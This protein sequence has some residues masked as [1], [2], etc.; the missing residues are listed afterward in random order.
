MKFRRR[1]RRASASKRSDGS[2]SRRHSNNRAKSW[3]DATTPPANRGFS[4]N[5]ACSSRRET[6]ARMFSRIFRLGIAKRI[7]SVPGLARDRQPDIVIIAF[8]ELRFRHTARRPAHRTEP[9]TFFRLSRRSELQHR[10]RQIRSSYSPIPARLGAGAPERTSFTLA[11]SCLRPNGL[12]R[13]CR[14]SA[15]SSLRRK[16]SSA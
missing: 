3:S 16:A 8:G 5:P 6:S 13:K 7:A 12:G 15:F 10:D 11:A 4:R 14:S 9:Q 2:V 1:A